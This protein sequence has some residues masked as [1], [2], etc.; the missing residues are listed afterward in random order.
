MG[1]F[2]WKRRHML[3]VISFLLFWL[4]RL[5]FGSVRIKIIN[6]D[7]YD[8][9]FL[10]SP[11]TRNIVAVTWHRNCIF[12][13][14]FLHTLDNFLIMSSPEAKVA[15]SLGK[16]FGLNFIHG[17]STAR[18]KDAL[19][20]MI[21]FMKKENEGR[22]CSTP[23][24]GPRGPP[25]VLKKGMLVLAKETNSLIIPMAWSGKRVITISKTWDKTIIP[26][27]YSQ[28]IVDFHPPLEISLDLSER[29]FEEICKKIEDILNEINDTVDRICGYSK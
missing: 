17:S 27:P 7:I 11:R 6:K 28:I 13:Y 10:K 3:D 1:S 8:E 24:D 25:R 29:E 5:W 4:T 16:R 15:V 19:K 21:E 26:L 22:I 20:I 14:Y 18:G 12:F 9:Y 23:V 2:S